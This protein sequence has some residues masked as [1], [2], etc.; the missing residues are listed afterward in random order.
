M[1]SKD[2][3]L[4]ASRSSLYD[5]S[6]ALL[7]CF[8]SL[9]PVKKKKASFFYQI[10]QPHPERKKKAGWTLTDD[11]PPCSL[12]QW[13]LEEPP[14]DWLLNLCRWGPASP[15]YPQR[16]PLDWLLPLTCILQSWGRASGH[17]MQE[18]TLHQGVRQRRGPGN[19]IHLPT[20]SPAPLTPSWES[21]HPAATPAHPPQG[22]R[23]W[24][25]IKTG[26]DVGS[27]SLNDLLFATFVAHGHTS[28]LWGVTQET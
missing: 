18:A 4:H 24:Q 7:K 13:R 25:E 11:D 8:I 10:F 14:A 3:H 26:E 15:R 22:R 6:F 19:H 1:H 28:T 21:A 16:V 5:F 9:N 23:D 27:S 12:T 20:V 2:V 17:G